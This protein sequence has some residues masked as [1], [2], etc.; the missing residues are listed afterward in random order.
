MKILLNKHMDPISTGRPGKES[1]AQ[2][3][4]GAK[5]KLDMHLTST[6]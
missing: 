4:K 6:V 1:I 2:R 3:R 5:K